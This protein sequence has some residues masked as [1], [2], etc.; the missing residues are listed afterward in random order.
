MNSTPILERLSEKETIQC[1]INMLYL[2]KY[3]QEKMGLY[4]FLIPEVKEMHD[5]EFQM[6]LMTLQQQL[7]LLA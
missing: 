2:R 4:K 1:K 3:A 7:E 6:E 5:S